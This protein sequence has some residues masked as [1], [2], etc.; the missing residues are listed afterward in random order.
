MNTYPICDSPLQI[1]VVQLCSETEIAPKLSFLFV[2]RSSFPYGFRVGTK[3][4]RYSMN[5]YPICGSP[6]KRSARSRFAPLQKWRQN[7]RFY[8]WREVLSRMVFVP[9][10]KAIRDSVNRYPICDSLLCRSAWSS[11]ARDRN[12]AEITVFN[13]KKKLYPVW[14]LCR[15]KSHPILCKYSWKSGL[16]G[17]AFIGR[18]HYIEGELLQSFPLKEL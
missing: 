11:L 8:V 2:K 10:R 14:I 5:T 12:R 15:F 1:G 16:K 18:W 9:T 7:H 6:L 13:C 17:V 4:T 3:A